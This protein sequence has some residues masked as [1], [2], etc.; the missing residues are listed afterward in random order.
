MLRWMSRVM[1]ENR[2]RNTYVIGSKRVVPIMD[3]MSK[4]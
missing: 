2:I 1:K 3:K 4:S